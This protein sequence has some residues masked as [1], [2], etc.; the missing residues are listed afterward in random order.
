MKKPKKTLLL[1]L[2]VMLGVD[3]AGAL[4]RFS[5]VIVTKKNDKCSEQKSIYKDDL[6]SCFGKSL[7]SFRC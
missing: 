4:L 3:G 5:G 1:Y 2:G 7:E 6:V